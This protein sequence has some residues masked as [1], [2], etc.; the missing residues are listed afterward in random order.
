[1][2]KLDKYLKEIEKR[3]NAATEGPW[4]WVKCRDYSVICGKGYDPQYPSIDPKMVMDD[5]SAGGE[6]S[7]AINEK[8]PNGRFIA[9]ARQDVG[10]LLEMVKKQCQLNKDLSGVDTNHYLQF[11]DEIESLIPGESGD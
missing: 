1:M 5:G 10:V 11:V 6:Y 2:N 3:L 8:D 7:S 9:H 4:E